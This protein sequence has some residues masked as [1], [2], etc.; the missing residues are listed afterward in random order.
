MRARLMTDGQSQ[1]AWTNGANN[2]G[3][4]GAGRIFPTW[5]AVRRAGGNFVAGTI[6]RLGVWATL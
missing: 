2:K 4:I 5:K 3:G 1:V 6:E